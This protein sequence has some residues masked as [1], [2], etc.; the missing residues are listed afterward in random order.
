MKKAEKIMLAFD[1][2]ISSGSISLWAG[3]K[4]I[5]Y[6]LGDDSVS[7]SE[8][9]LVNISFLLEQEGISKRSIDII[10]VSLGPGSYTGIRVGIATAQGLSTS[11]GVKIIGVSSLYVLAQ[12]AIPQNRCL[13]GIW[14]GR[15][16]VV[17]QIFDKKHA[18]KPINKPNLVSLTSIVEVASEEKTAVILDKKAFNVFKKNNIE[19]KAHKA[20]D[21]TAEL[22]GKLA[23]QKLMRNEYSNLVP[24]YAREFSVT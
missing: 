17:Y 12:E 5:A 19:A 3:E 13:V 6:S 23:L 2:S 20:S 18:S 10:A 11:L 22:V 14:A 15:D 1:T 21:N 7:R 4:Q 16:E 8:D 9:L 24:I